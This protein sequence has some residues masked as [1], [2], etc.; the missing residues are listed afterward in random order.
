MSD[1]SLAE[2][3]FC[4]LCSQAYV[5]M[6]TE[7][8]WGPALNRVKKGEFCKTIGCIRFTCKQYKNLLLCDYTLTMFTFV[9]EWTIATRSAWESA[10]GWI[11]LTVKLMLRKTRPVL[12]FECSKIQ[13]NCYK[14]FHTTKPTNAL[15]FRLALFLHTIFHNSDMLRSIVII[16]KDLVDINKTYTKILMND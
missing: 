14:S 15:M 12:I 11:E 13:K 4:V 6:Y 3:T 7:F 10:H 16:F 8:V 9:N 5:Q 1:H 2:A